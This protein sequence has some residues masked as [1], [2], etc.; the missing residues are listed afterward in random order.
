METLKKSWY[1]FGIGNEI[2]DITKKRNRRESMKVALITDSKVDKIDDQMRLWTVCHVMGKYG[3]EPEVWF[4]KNDKNKQNNGEGSFFQKLMK[5]FRKEE[6]IEVVVQ[7]LLE[8]KGI[9]LKEYGSFDEL[10][11]AD[12]TVDSYLF[13]QMQGKKEQLEELSQLQFITT[14]QKYGIKQDPIFWL[15]EK[16]LE[17]FQIKPEKN[18]G[19]VFDIQSPSKQQEKKVLQLREHIVGKVVNLE[20]QGASEKELKRYIQ[21][22]AGASKFITNTALGAIIA[23]IYHVPFIYLAKEENDPIATILQELQLEKHIIQN[24]DILDDDFTW[25]VEPKVMD[26]RLRKWRRTPLYEIEEGFHMTS[27]EER[28]LCPTNILKKECYGCYACEKICPTKA[29]TMV[30]DEEGFPYPVTNEETCIQCGACERACI[31][32]KETKCVEEGFPRVRAANNKNTKIRQ[33]IS[34]SG[35]IFPELCREIIE[36]RQGVVVGVAYDENMNV[37]SKIAQTMEEAKE[38]CNSKYVKSHFAHNF[39]KV[40]ELLQQGRHV[41]YTGLPCEC[42]ALRSY[43]KK[44]YDNLLIEE[45]LCHA[46][47]SQKVFK[48]YIQSLEEIYGS[49]VV[50]FVFRDK[51]EGWRWSKCKMSIT[52]EDG[53]EFSDYTRLDDYFK[54]FFNDYLVRPSCSNCQFVGGHRCG[55]LTTGD[56]WGV[57]NEFP[58]LYDNKG[59]S[60]LIINTEKGWN[61]WQA[62]E[63]RFDVEKSR[64]KQAFRYNHSK[65]IAYKEER[66]QFFQRIKGKTS[67]E[68]G[69]ILFE[70]NN[71]PQKRRHK[72]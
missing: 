6:K 17:Q 51:K 44:D 14:D 63:D 15:Q 23:I 10:K 37:V 16:D 21:R 62:I 38:F 5:L 25:E 48:Q 39:P 49:K 40:K 70:Y 34:S 8:S 71:A 72:K 27:N 67:K 42:A 28:V 32:L 13:I 45:I 54:A 2:T 19:I 41:L 55:D 50:N 7:S 36:N 9:S 12:S 53:R 57:Q 59:T 22:C 4:I 65:P 20:R 47:P 1:Y 35:G 31:R 69:D 33:G 30:E 43:L 58:H 46:G 29:I 52:F 26:T 68:V 18:V 64:M 61:Y 3:I 56:F 24:D 66:A 60:L 11:Q